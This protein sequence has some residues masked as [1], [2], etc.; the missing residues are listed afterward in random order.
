MDERFY[1]Q[2]DS[3]FD[4]PYTINGSLE[5]WRN[6]VARYAVG[7]SRLAFAISAG[8]AGPLLLP[9]D[10]ESGGFHLRGGSSVGKSTVLTAAGSSWGGRDF[11]RTWRATSNGLESV[12]A[13]HNDGLLC[14][15][16]LSQVDSREAGQIAYLI[17][18]GVGKTRAG[19]SGEA[20]K[21]LRWRTLFLSTGEIDLAT[22]IAEDG[23]GRRVAAGQEAR[24][25]DLPADAGAGL[26]IF[27]DLHGLASAADLAQHL[28]AAAARHHGHA[29]PAFIRFLTRD[30]GG[31]GPLVAE[32]QREFLTEALPEGA[33]GQVRRVAGRFALVAA[34]GEMVTSFGILPWPQGEATKACRRCLADWIAQRGGVEPAE[35]REAVSA[36]RRFIQGHGSSRFE[37]MG[38]LVHHDSTGTPIDVRIQNRAGFRRRRGNGGTEFLVLPEVWKTEICQ[39]MDSM[40]VAKVLAEHGLLK[41]DGQGKFQTLHRVLGS[42]GPIRC[43]ALLPGILGDEG[44]GDGS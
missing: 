11:I 31:I 40:R 2:S 3:S 29:A 10:S 18:N 39:G 20:R 41:T 43:Y 9:T 25:V 24:L 23:R 4:D 42:S 26:G 12:A 16:E 34:A 27:E 32:H 14:L 1:F 6:E 17:A 44:E 36:V 22:K 37:P 28:K 35:D 8:F 15:D 19:R 13:L 33:D 5:G 21:A 7:N 30:F 38:D